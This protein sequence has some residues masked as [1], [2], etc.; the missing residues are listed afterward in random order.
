MAYDPRQAL[1]HLRQRVQQAGRLVLA[2]GVYIDRQIAL[3]DFLCSLYRALHWGG[4]G[5]CSEHSEPQAQQ[6][7]NTGTNPKHPLACDGGT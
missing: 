3:A 2:M 4:D 7:R 6:Q 5:A 1:L